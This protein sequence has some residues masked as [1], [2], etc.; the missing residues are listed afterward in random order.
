MSCLG[1]SGLTDSI[2]QLFEIQPD[3]LRAMTDEISSANIPYKAYYA[4]YQSGGWYTAIL[5]SPGVGYS[6]GTVRDGVAN[7]TPLVQ[8]L[9]VT[10]R[11]LEELGL[12]YFA[13]R[14]ACNN[15][16][17]WLWEHRDYIELDEKKRRL[18]LHVPLI[19]N[20]NAVMQF[21]QCKVRMAPGWIWKLDP[22]V[23]HAISNTGTD[24][25]THLILD[26]YRNQTLR[27]MLDHERLEAE[28]VQPLPL[29]DAEE[30]RRLLKQAQDLLTQKGTDKAEQYL[31]KTFHKFDLG[32][33]TSYDI[34]INLY[35]DMGF[36]NRE[37]YWIAQ[38]IARV[39]SR[40]KIDPN[41]GVGNARGK[42][43]S[44]PHPSTSNLPQLS[45]F[46]Q[47]LRTCRQYS[48]LK[49]A[50]VRGSLARGDGD[51]HSDIDL[52]CVVAPQEFASF[53]KQVDAGIKEQHNP[54]AEEWVDT[55]VKDFGG[56]GFVYL[57]ETDK[58]LYQLDLYVACQG[59]PSLD[60][61]NRVP[62]KQE[63][64]RRNSKADGAQRR[65]ALY[66]RLHSEMIEQQIRRINGVEPS[67]SRT[68]TELCVLGFMIKKCLE[69]GDEFVASNEYNMWKNCFIKL[70]RH[71][72]DTQHRDYG[73]YHVKRLIIEA[74]DNGIL[75]KDLCAMNN[76]PLTRENFT[77]AH[78]YAMDFVQKHFPEDYA[79]QQ[80]MIHAVTRHIEGYK[81]EPLVCQSAPCMHITLKLPQ[82][83][84]LREPQYVPI[85]S[86]KSH[87]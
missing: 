74:N 1:N 63:I 31:L 38:Q 48:G 82:C 83:A 26:C 9:P 68:L 25:R 27:K 7:P 56:V 69:R 37:N 79:R 62:H 14:I 17:S 41:P 11:F 4:D 65:D 45:I 13:V 22:T 50:Y 20:P 49:Q 55:I 58:G 40:D 71:K 21:S 80:R 10:Q 87:F 57:L 64:F 2:S 42:L 33:E 23:S 35:R 67:V 28:H 54:I 77:H 52:L 51:P 24:S 86:E 8:Y 85:R 72:F 61:L 15:P 34:L 78:C 73:F 43:F 70:V 3:M 53:I 44:N 16:D 39:Y 66:Y 6:D 30:R 18:R 29:L 32:E 84:R 59:H 75:Y 36:R 46:R 60:Y 19:T 76:H 47:I 12:D 5:Y 81:P